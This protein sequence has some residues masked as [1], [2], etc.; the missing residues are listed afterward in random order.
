M[1]WTVCAGYFDCRISRFD[2]V[3]RDEGE[4]YVCAEERYIAELRSVN[5][6]CAPSPTQQL[7]LLPQ[8]ILLIPTSSSGIP[9]QL[10]PPRPRTTTIHPTPILS[11]S[12]AQSL[13]PIAI[14]TTTPQTSTPVSHIASTATVPQPSSQVS[15]ITHLPPSNH[16]L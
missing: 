9:E 16:H 4:W 5:S 11:N 7:L 14:P 8:L 2:I 15:A 12:I 6:S 3:G 10:H 13:K 1:S